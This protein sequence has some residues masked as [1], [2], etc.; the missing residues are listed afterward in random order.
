LSVVVRIMVTLDVMSSSRTKKTAQ[1]QLAEA[2]KIKFIVEEF[3]LV[4]RHTT[5]DVISAREIGR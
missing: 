1:T 2:V 4:F 5:E 3:H